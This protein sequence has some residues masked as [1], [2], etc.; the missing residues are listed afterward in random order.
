MTRKTWIQ[1]GVAAIIGGLAVGCGTMGKT[2][3][4]RANSLFKYLYSKSEL[5]AWVPKL[6]TLAERAGKV[7]ALMNNCYQDYG[8]HNAADLAGLLA[9]SLAGS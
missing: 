8:V 7:H 2:R 1:I 4:R 6:Q 9:D 5:R 3:A